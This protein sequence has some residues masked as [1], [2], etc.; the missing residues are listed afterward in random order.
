LL[1]Q[2][3]YLEKQVIFIQEAIEKRKQQQLAIK[4]IGEEKEAA[5]NAAIEKTKTFKE[6]LLEKMEAF[7]KWKDDSI[8]GWQNWLSQVNS[9]ISSVRSAPTGGGSSPIIARTSV[10]DTMLNAG[11]QH[12]Q[13]GGVVPGLGAQLAVVHGGETIIPKGKVTKALPQVVVNI[14]GNSFMSD[15]DSAEKIGDMIIERLKTQM[16]FIY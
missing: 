10:V 14:T 15:E 4:M 7:D 2:K 16:R 13:E 6:K 5:I 11:F 12:Y 8:S 3:A 1:A 9:I